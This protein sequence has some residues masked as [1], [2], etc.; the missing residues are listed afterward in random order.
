MSSLI[1]GATGWPSRI[2]RSHRA[3]SR[4]DRSRAQDLLIC[5]LIESDPSEQA[6]QLLTLWPLLLIISLLFALFGIRR[7]AGVALVLPFHSNRRVHGAFLS[8]Q[9]WGSHLRSLA[10]VDAPARKHVLDPFRVEG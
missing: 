1:G 6:E 8:K 10:P 9:L 2:R 3:E 4:C 7:R 5:V